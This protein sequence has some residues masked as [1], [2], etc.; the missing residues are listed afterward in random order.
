MV[1]SEPF[2]DSYLGIIERAPVN[3]F[4]SSKTTS[5]FVLE[6]IHSH[7]TFLVDACTTKNLGESLG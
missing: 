2:S 1:I 7:N 3:V 5:I 4:G 6:T